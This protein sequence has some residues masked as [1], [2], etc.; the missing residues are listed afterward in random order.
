MGMPWVKAWATG[1]GEASSPAPAGRQESETHVPVSL[2]GQELMTLP[3]HPQR[4]DRLSTCMGAAVTLGKLREVARLWC[5]WAVWS[6]VDLDQISWLLE[7]SL[8][9]D[10]PLQS[11]ALSSLPVVLA[12]APLAIACLW[13]TCHW[14]GWRVTAAE[15]CLIHSSWKWLVFSGTSQ[16]L[17]ALSCK[18]YDFTMKKPAEVG[19]NLLAR[20]GAL[21]YS[22]L[23]KRTF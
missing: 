20:F 4:C 2:Q 17:V 22:E 5:V 15:S 14:D 16:Q 1:T 9:P 21:D 10:D 18:W 12:C 19:C 3:C 7:Q 13:V 23:R 11:A 8:L 6:V